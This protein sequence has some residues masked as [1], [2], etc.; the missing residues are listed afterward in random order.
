V[1]VLFDGNHPQPLLAKE[2]SMMAARETV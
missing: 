1:N 2:G